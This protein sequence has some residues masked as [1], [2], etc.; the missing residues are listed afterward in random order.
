MRIAVISSIA[1]FA[2]PLRAQPPVPDLAPAPAVA[3]PCAAAPCPEKPRSR[4][5]GGHT[6]MTPAAIDSAWVETT[7]ANRLSGRYQ[8][9]PDVP[10][11]NNAVTINSLGIRENV[12]FEVAFAD[13][14]AAGVGLF[15][16]F[17]TGITGTAIATQG[18]LFSY[19]ATLTGAFR[20]LREE[21]SATQLTA[22]AEL[23]GVQ[24]GGRISLATFLK[25]LRN[26][27]LRDVPDLISNFGDFLVTPASSY[28]GGLSLNLAQALTPA[29]SLQGSLRLELRQLKQSPFVPGTGRVDSTSTSWLPQAGVAFGVEPPGFPFAFLAEYRF[30]TRDDN[31]ILGPAHHLIALGGYYAGRPDLQLGPVV[32][33]EFGLPHLNGI[34]ADGNPLGSANGTALSFQLMMR[35]F[36]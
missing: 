11:G 7:F 20:I 18:A 31:D 30:A 36:W 3:A 28:G 6:F 22:R 33:G 17:A 9:V 23:F 34:D 2:A 29:L 14:W 10:I 16:E 27:A 13:R 15:G 12:D 21:S 35:Y 4:T 5:V 25:T 24:G 32:F 19:G 8:T 1:L 26:T